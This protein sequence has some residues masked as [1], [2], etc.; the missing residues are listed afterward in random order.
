[1]NKYTINKVFEKAFNHPIWK[2]EADCLHHNLAIEG[3]NPDNTL[4]TFTICSF[5]GK[6]LLEDYS[7]EEKEWTLAAVQGEYLI[8]KKY[9]ASAP[10]QAGIQIYHYPT[11]TI[12]AQFSEYVLQ[13]VRNQYIIALHRSIPSGLTFSIHIASGKV[14]NKPMAEIDDYPTNVEIPNPYNGKIPSFMSQI[15][16]EENFWLQAKLPYFIWTYY[17]KAED[18]YTL[19]LLLSSKDETLDKIEV[20]N[21]L[22]KLIH[23]PYFAV[24]NYIFFLSNTKQEIITYLV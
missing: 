4:P 13:E 3:R 20:L 15:T 9:G 7:P 2:I 11:Q 21:N 23:Q 22:N 6:T 16:F 14:S 8:L 19:N 18:K 24:H 5:E 17:Q 12:L 10:I 1:M